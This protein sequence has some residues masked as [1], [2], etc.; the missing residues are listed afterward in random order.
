MRLLYRLMDTRYI[1]DKM[2]AIFENVCCKAVEEGYGIDLAECKLGPAAVDVIKRYETKVKFI[3]SA[4]PYLNKILEDNRNAVTA[5]LVD[6]PALSIPQI[7]TE[8]NIRDYILGIPSGQYKAVL[9]KV[10]TIPI[11]AVLVCLILLCRPDIELDLEDCTAYVFDRFREKLNIEDFLDKGYTEFLKAEGPIVYTIKCD[12]AEFHVNNEL[13]P[14][15]IGSTTIYNIG[16]N[17]FSSELYK[18][19]IVDLLTE[20]RTYING[21]HN[22]FY[23][24]LIDLLQ[25]KEDCIDDY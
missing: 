17:K 2:S 21:K 12:D 16:V 3:N 22:E 24:K 14:A 7:T 15:E 25:Y 11:N 23:L 19:L 4:D 5:V 1:I 20:L 9:N 18:A 13:I 6:Y 10:N 8:F